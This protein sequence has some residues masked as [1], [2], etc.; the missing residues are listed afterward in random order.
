MIGQCTIRTVILDYQRNAL[1]NN[2]GN[3][4]GLNSRKHFF[5]SCCV[6]DWTGLFYYRSFLLFQTSAT[7][8]S[9]KHV[10]TI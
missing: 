10:S 9:K 5:M 2:P 4:G 6:L 8:D 3:D 1:H 7:T